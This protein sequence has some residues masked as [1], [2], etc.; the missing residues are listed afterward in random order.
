[1]GAEYG[2]YPQGPPMND[3]TNINGGGSFNQGNQYQKHG[4][5]SAEDEKNM[6]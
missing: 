1:M 5:L 2:D 3:M 6:T 4:Y